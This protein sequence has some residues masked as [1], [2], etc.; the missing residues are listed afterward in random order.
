[1][2]TGSSDCMTYVTINGD[3]TGF[4]C[5]STKRIDNSPAK[6]WKLVNKLR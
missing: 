2:I 6:S 4:V 1:M 5:E 3:R